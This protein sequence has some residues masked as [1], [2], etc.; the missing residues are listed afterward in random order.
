MDV[1]FQL[2]NKSKREAQAI[3]AEINPGLKSARKLDFDLIEDEELR[4]KL[5]RVKGLFAAVDPNMSLEDVLHRLCDQELGKRSK[6]PLRDVRQKI[7]RQSASPAPARVE[8]ST[9]ISKAEVRRQVWRRDQGRCTNC[10]SRY[11]LE[12]DHILPKALGGLWTVNN[13]RLLCR[14]CN[15]NAATKVFGLRKMD[16]YINGQR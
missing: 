1:L 11:A 5:L 13:L 14:P 10:E 12:I 8:E 3:V 9:G 7:V 4:G 15:Q 16:R 6:E 2:E